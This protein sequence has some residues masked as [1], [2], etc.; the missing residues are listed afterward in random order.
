VSAKFPRIPDSVRREEDALTHSLMGNLSPPNRDQ[1]T[2]KGG[3]KSA[4]AVKSRRLNV[5]NGYS[6]QNPC[7][8]LGSRGIV[9]RERKAKP[10][11]FVIF[12]MPIASALNIV[13]TLHFALLRHVPVREPF[14]LLLIGATLVGLATT[15]RGRV[16][17]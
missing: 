8:K 12:H 17:Q 2:G 3:E 10:L 1:R 7:Q 11:A 14:A 4:S 13:G 6:V 9:N 15:V 5:S 16:R